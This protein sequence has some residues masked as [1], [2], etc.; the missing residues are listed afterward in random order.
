MR[1]IV[2]LLGLGGL[3]YA[4]LALYIWLFQSRFIYFPNEPT[5]Q[6]QATPLD[7]GLDFVDVRF[8]AS[9]GVSL[10]GWF[11]PGGNGPV[12]LF[13]H[14][15]AGNIS[16]RLDSIRL[17]NRLGADVFIIDYRGYG[18]S[19]GTAD[20]DGTYRDARAAWDYLTTERGIDRSRIVVF[21]RSLGGAVAAWL[22]T[23]VSPRALILES[24]FS[25][26]RDMARAAFPFLPTSLARI[27]YDT[28]S[29]MASIACPILLMHSRDDEIIPYQMGEK[30]YAAAAG[31]A[32]L[33][34]LQGGHNDAH[35]RTGDH[36]VET[37]RNFLSPQL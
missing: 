18:R 5:R 31:N 30:L 10:H 37:L 13:F 1:T 28:E 34:T 2:L 23:D 20:E 29:R 27:R 12:I 8:D 9:D 11:V 7:T 17:F 16:H 15:N 33:K 4:G 24:T 25:S 6:L 22:A 21:G 26:V 3:L 32:I 36:Y 35:L 14:G 19:D